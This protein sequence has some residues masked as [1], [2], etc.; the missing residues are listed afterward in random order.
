MTGSE[1]LHG[2]IARAADP[3]DQ[4]DVA[5]RRTLVAELRLVLAM[6]PSVEGGGPI[7]AGPI[8]GEESGAPNLCTLGKRLTPACQE[9]LLAG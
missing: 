2:I 4:D 9:C 8:T 6:C 5:A 1:R 3:N 7:A